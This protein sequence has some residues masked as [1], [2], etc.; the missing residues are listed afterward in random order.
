MMK[1]FFSLIFVH[2]ILCSTFAQNFPIEKLCLQ[3]DRETYVTG[4]PILFKL[5]V[6]DAA[7]HRPSTVSKIGY[8]VL[9][10]THSTAIRQLRVRID[11]GEANG[12]I[13]LP[14]T[15]S[16]GLYQIVAFTNLQRNYDEKFYFQ[17]QLTII[18]QSDTNFDFYKNKAK[19]A[20]EQ[21]I[22]TNGQL[23]IECDSTPY[24]PCQRV[25]IKLH[26]VPSGANVAVSV[27][28]SK[29][30]HACKQPE[31]DQNTEYK[32]ATNY[33]YLPET[34]G[35]ILKGEVIDA[36]SQQKIKNAV[37]LLS[38]IDTVPNLKY[39]ITDSEGKFR[40]FL[41]NYYDG[42]ELFLTIKDSSKKCKLEN[43]S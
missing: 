5:N 37:V 20:N 11:N 17:K 10:N 31:I 43:Q 39:A 8:I 22:N 7:T 3:T 24:K 30:Q 2:C 40:L 42:Q 34:K 9:R 32:P 6:L 16:S 1:Y 14:D 33:T 28:E 21:L 4:E 27:F 35:S 13:T 15:L 41:N 25:A 12:N 26:S 36:T 29:N 18:S 38:R 23:T 19:P